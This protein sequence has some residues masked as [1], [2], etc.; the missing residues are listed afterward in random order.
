MTTHELKTWPAFFE[1]IADGRKNFEIRLDDRGFQAGD[2]VLLRE[3]DPAIR[4]GGLSL[5]ASQYT[6]RE[7]TADIGYVLHAVP[8][9][10]ASRF[11]EQTQPGVNLGGHVVFSLLNVAEV[12]S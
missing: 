5:T 11:G 1:A 7:L 3:W 2:K 12:S 9:A 8:H 4:T 10:F 6:G